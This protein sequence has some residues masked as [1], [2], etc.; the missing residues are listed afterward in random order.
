MEVLELEG[1]SN[2]CLHTPPTLFIGESLYDIRQ[3][4]LSIHHGCIAFDVPFH[5]WL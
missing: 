3:F 5:D 1:D 2:C 4:C